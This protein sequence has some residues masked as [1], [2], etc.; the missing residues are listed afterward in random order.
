MA[1][2]SSFAGLKPEIPASDLMGIPTDFVVTSE[3]LPQVRE[4]A[5]KLH[6]QRYIQE[7]QRAEE[8]MEAAEV[9]A[10]DLPSKKIDV[11]VLS[12][13]CQPWSLL[14]D[15]GGSS[16]RTQSHPDDHPWWSQT[17]HL[18]PVFLKKTGVSGVLLEQV[19]QGFAT[20]C[21]DDDENAESDALKFLKLLVSLYADGGVRYVKLNLSSWAEGF[22]RSRISFFVDYQGIGLG[23]R[24]SGCMFVCM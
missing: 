10:P 17:F 7:Y 12:P 14:R 16:A 5:M 21:D 3:L 8:H 6:G 4:A 2:C 20:G 24:L 11:A 13:A 23:V 19:W 22:S 18:V 9:A 15:R 1:M